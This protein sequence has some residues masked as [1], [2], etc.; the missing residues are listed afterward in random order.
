MSSA[1]LARSSVAFPLVGLVLLLAGCGACHLAPLPLDTPMSAPAAPAIPTN[2]GS[3]TFP[4]GPDVTLS[5]SPTPYDPEEVYRRATNSLS[6]VLLFKPAEG[7][8][9]DLTFRLAPL[10]LQEVGD[11]SQPDALQRD[12]IGKLDP[13]DSHRDSSGFQPRMYIETDAIP[14]NGQAHVRLT[15]WWRYAHHPTEPAATAVQGLRITLN[16]AAEPCIWEVLADRS[17]AELIFVAQSLE[18]TARAQYGAPLPGR[19]FAIECASA[20]AP[21]VIVA[22]VIE[23]GP[24]PMVP[25]VYLRAGTRSVSTLTC[26]CMPAQAKRVLATRVYQLVPIQRS[27]ENPDEMTLGVREGNPL[28][29]PLGAEPGEPRIARCLRLPREF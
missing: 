11:T 16:R 22:R 15:Y 19:R 28:A 4:R 2:L 7:S 9:T 24:T 27:S 26:R 6:S 17:P 1:P 3:A 13:T 21:K 14:I 25:L 12:V 8:N 18:S 10:I 29:F 5:I 23:D 20:A